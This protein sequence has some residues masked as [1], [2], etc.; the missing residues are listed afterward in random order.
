[1]WHQNTHHHHGSAIM[2]LGILIGMAPAIMVVSAIPVSPLPVLEKAENHVSELSKIVLDL[3]KSLRARDCGD[4]L[5]AGQINNGVY[6]IFPT[7]DSKGTSVYCDMNTDGGGWTVIQNRG[8]YGNS[9]YYFYRN[10]TEYANGFGNRDKEYWTGNDVLHTLTSQ[11]RGF[12]LRIELKNETGESLVANYKI[13]KVASQ[14]D[15]YKMTVGGYSGPP[16]SDSFSYTNGINFST[17]DSDNDNHSSNCATTYKGGWWY[18]AC[19]S[20]NL[21]GLNL[22]GPHT[23]FADGIE[24]SRRNHV[25]G[26]HHYSYPEARMMIREANSLPEAV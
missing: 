25:G 6:V 17:F 10:W 9:V 13:F 21:N 3:K 19:H 5:K 23:S 14:A 7:S 12:T 15:R 2:L 22:N 18:A 8:Q 1:M 16:G 24:W 11:D 4:L 26:L 20:S